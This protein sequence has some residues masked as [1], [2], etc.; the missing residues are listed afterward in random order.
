MADAQAQSRLW[1]RF[2]ES[3][4]GFFSVYESDW[5]T[6]FGAKFG[7][8]DLSDSQCSIVQEFMALLVASGADYTR[9]CRALYDAY[10]A[11]DVS[12]LMDPF[13]AKPF[14]EDQRARLTQWWSMWRDALDRDGRGGVA[15]RLRLNNPYVIP[16]NHQV[17]RVIAQAES[18]DV[19]PLQALMNAC[20]TPFEPSPSTEPFAVPPTD[21]E[22]VTTTFCGT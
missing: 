9:T 21:S 7:F 18:G 3:L 20:S 11:D 5:R 22:R 4:D 1:G 16:R 14:T 6:V 17:A 12:V 10:S 8:T 2:S 15:D 13:L 19:A